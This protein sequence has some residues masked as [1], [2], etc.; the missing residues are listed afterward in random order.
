MRSFVQL[1]EV[2]LIL[3]NWQGTNHK[4]VNS[5]SAYI[6]YQHSK[7]VNSHTTIREYTWNSHFSVVI[8]SVC[9]MRGG[10]TCT[11]ASDWNDLYQLMACEHTQ[12]NESAIWDVVKFSRII[13]QRYTWAGDQ[14]QVI[15]LEWPCRRSFIIIIHHYVINPLLI[16]LGPSEL[17]N[18]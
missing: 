12:Y 7:K 9:A 2:T 13:I 15:L 8:G 11:Y 6:S 1:Q 5:T 14:K 18:N 17:I 10:S 16:I 4:N 3:F